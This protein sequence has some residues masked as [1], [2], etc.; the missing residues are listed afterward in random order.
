MRCQRALI[1]ALRVTVAGAIYQSATPIAA[2]SWAGAQPAEQMIGA[3]CAAAG[4]T[5]I[6][7]GVPA[8]LRNMSVSGSAIDQIET[9]RE[10]T[11]GGCRSASSLTSVP[12]PVTEHVESWQSKTGANS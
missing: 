11:Q 12:N 1:P 9:L 8:V 4:L 3:T 7:N 5:L 2:N 10:V 6:N